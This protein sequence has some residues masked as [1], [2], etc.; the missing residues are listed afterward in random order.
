M[1]KSTER[2]ETPL[3]LEDMYDYI[4]DLK[5]ASYT[6]KNIKGNNTPKTEIGFIAQ[7]IV[8]NKVG[9]Y[10][11]NSNDSENLVYD[12]GNRVSVLEGALKIVIEKI[13]ILEEEVLN[14]NNQLN[15]SIK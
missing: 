3:M 13:E 4:K 12:M 6:L 15:N 8:G 2:G 9:D 5:L 11:I 7:D 14:L 1:S 10:I